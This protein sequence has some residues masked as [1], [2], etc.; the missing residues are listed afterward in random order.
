ML[1]TWMVLLLVAQ[2]PGAK[3]QEKGGKEAAA[4]TPEGAIRTFIVAMMTKDAAVLRS[5]TLPADGLDVLLQGQAISPDAV[6]GFKAQVAGLPVQLLKA[7]EEVTLAD[8]RKYKAR[9]EGVGPDCAVV[10]PK[11][12]SFP[13][14]CRK[15]DGR[16]R[17]DAAPIIASMKGSGDARKSIDPAGIKE[18]VAIRL[19]Q[20]LDIQFQQEGGAIS[21][22]VVVDKPRAGV[23][24]LHVDFKKQGE[25]LM[26]ATQN[27]FPKD[28]TFRA[29]A[30]YKGRKSYF[31]TSIV[32][33]KAGLFGLELWQDPIEE[34]VLFDFK[35]ADDKP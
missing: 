3:A 30:R 27:P 34:L 26:L 22:P 25:S 18:K 5:V 20:K 21:G 28:L 24:T 32:P 7:G 14:L 15:D 31:E 2:N 10:L 35:L 1:A 19:N 23:P 33:V 16:W 12:A 29:L 17:V 11:G 4:E 9:A 8:G 6:E 13:V